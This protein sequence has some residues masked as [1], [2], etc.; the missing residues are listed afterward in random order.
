MGLQRNEKKGQ[1]DPVQ[2]VEHLG[3]EVDLKLGQFRVTEK[4]VRKI[5]AKAT[6]ILCDAARN[7]SHVLHPSKTVSYLTPEE[8]KSSSTCTTP[9]VTVDSKIEVFWEDDDCF[10]PGVVKKFNED[11]KAYVLYDDGDKETL[12]FSKENFKIIGSTA[13]SEPT[14]EAADTTEEN[15]DCG[16]NYETYKRGGAVENFLTHSL[17]ERWRKE[18]GQSR[19]TELAVKMQ[20][21]SLLDTTISNYGP[22]ARRFIHFCVQQ[23]RPWLP[24]T[25]A[26]VV[27]YVAAVLE[28]GGVRPP[29][30]QPYLSAVNNYHEDLG[31]PGPAKGRVVTRAVKGMAA[32]QAEAAVEDENIETQRT[33]LPAGHVQ[34]VH[35]AAL[36]HVQCTDTDFSVVLLKETGASVALATTPRCSMEP[37]FENSA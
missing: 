1:W 6:E 12:D 3:L 2:V 13:V 27:L 14:N 7:R 25:E 32:I 28:D 4:R 22:K 35:E 36:K 30:M 18:L 9:T 11:G 10:Y 31:F 33:W 23:G 21:K 19:L 5:H 29:S 16:G 8:H 20:R 24:A 17:C 37:D 15:T 34:R 26:T